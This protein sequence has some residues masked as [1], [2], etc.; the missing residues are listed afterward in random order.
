MA[1]GALLACYKLANITSAQLISVSDYLAVHMRAF[2]G[3]TADAVVHNPVKPL[4]LEK[5]ESQ[6]QRNYI[7]YVG[8]LVAY[9]NIDRVLMPV[10][11]LLNENPEL[12]A[13][14]I[15]DGPER[16]RLQQMAANH[17]RVEFMG[18]PSDSQVREHLR[19]TKIF[20]SGHVTEGFGITYVEALSQGCVVAMPASGGGIEIALQRVGSSVQLLPISLNRQ[21]VLVVLRCA[22][23][24]EAPMPVES[25]S[26]RAVAS[27]YL[28]VD[29]RFS[30]T[31][32]SGQRCSR[33]A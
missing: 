8:R 17:P 9:K 18:Q 13:C 5:D 4:Y 27:A 31:G 7:T 12:R 16:Q 24:I 14:I 11:D 1:T 32:A 15:G 19:R 21:E 26:A 33:T 10:F 23:K 29:R 22:L 20:V 28:D 3:I 6:V 25:Y 2:Y 30:P